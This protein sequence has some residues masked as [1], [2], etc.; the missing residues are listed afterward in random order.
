[1]GGMLVLPTS[2]SHK[3]L[4]S[5]QLTLWVMPWQH[6]PHAA[7]REHCKQ[8]A[9]SPSVTG[10]MALPGRVGGC[11]GMGGGTSGDSWCQS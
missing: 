8:Q 2:L 7:Q 11:S 10:I 6:H 3:V 5:K 1:M 4:Q 9:V